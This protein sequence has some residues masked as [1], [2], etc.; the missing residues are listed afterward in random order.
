M[1]RDLCSAFTRQL[2]ARGLNDQAEDLKYRI[3]GKYRIQ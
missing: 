3:S 1:L 2:A